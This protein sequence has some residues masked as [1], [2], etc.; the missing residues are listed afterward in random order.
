MYWPPVT[1]IGVQNKLEWTSYGTVD[2]VR[3]AKVFIRDERLTVDDRYL[4]ACDCCLEDAIQ[5]IRAKV[6]ENYEASLDIFQAQSKK[7]FFK[8]SRHPLTHYW[9]CYEKEGSKCLE[10]FSYKT[11]SFVHLNIV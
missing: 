9:T 6:V 11:F 7:R 4:L 1:H 8:Q 5:E 3:S 2:L 10:R